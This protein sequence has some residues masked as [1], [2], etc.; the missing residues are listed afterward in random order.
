MS[1]SDDTEESIT[2]QISEPISEEQI[3]EVGSFDETYA[4]FAESYGATR[5]LISNSGPATVEDNLFIREV[6]SNSEDSELFFKTMKEQT[7]RFR[8]LSKGC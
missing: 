1:C 6:K 8:N 5:F 2:G 3:E 7:E 4:S